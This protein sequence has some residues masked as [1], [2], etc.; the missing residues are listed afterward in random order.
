MAGQLDYHGVVYGFHA[1]MRRKREKE[2]EK[3]I[4]EG[5]EGR[6]ILDCCFLLYR[7]E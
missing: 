5:R 3:C 6:S 2:D 4:H 1:N 7:F